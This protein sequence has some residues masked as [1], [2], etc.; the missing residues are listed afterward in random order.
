MIS[1]LGEY[2]SALTDKTPS[3]LRAV[4]RHLLLAKDTALYEGLQKSVLYG[5]FIAK[6]VQYD[7]L[8]KVKKVPSKEAVVTVSAEFISY[9]H[10]PG[11]GRDYLE[12]IGL[13]WF[14]NYKLRSVK[15]AANTI[16]NNPLYALMYAGV[17]G[18]QLGIDS[19]I[20]SNV[21]SQVF[22][23][24]IGYSLG[25]GMGIDGIFANPYGQLIH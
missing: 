24:S 13:L 11:R 3:G 8:T 18:S 10:L 15:V 17:G 12:S 4:G 19:P 2:M 5:D 6:A 7:Y 22:D 25:I 16:R 1:R 21:V 9:D 14:Y 23:G 20:D